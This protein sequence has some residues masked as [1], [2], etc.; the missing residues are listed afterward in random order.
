[1]YQIADK[2][3]FGVEVFNSLMVF[4]ATDSSEGSFVVDSN[5]DVWDIK[6][7]FQKCLVLPNVA[8]TSVQHR[9]YMG[10][11]PQFIIIT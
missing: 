6:L 4:W 2:M 9:T 11:L 3:V 10:Q 8:E 5:I 1:M 7:I